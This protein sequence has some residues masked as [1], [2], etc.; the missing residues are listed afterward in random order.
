MQTIDWVCYTSDDRLGHFRQETFFYPVKKDGYVCDVD[1]IG[2]IV[3]E[4]ENEEFT[5]TSGEVSFNG[6]EYIPYHYEHA[7]E[8]MLTT[9]RKQYKNIYRHQTFDLTALSYDQALHVMSNIPLGRIDEKAPFV[10]WL[11]SIK[12]PNGLI[13]NV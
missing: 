7:D 12:M 1:N 8:I 13:I 11:A 6:G 9:D 3:T 4:H 2:G 5:A 10:N